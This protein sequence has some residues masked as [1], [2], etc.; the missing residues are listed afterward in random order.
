MKVS[1]SKKTRINAFI[2]ATIGRESQ[3]PEMSLRAAGN[4][5]ARCAA[6]LNAYRNARQSKSSSTNLKTNPGV[7]SMFNVHYI[8]DCSLYERLNNKK[9]GS[10]EIGDIASYQH[11]P[12]GEPGDTAPLGTTTASFQSVPPIFDAHGRVIFKIDPQTEE[13]VPMT[14]LPAPLPKAAGTLQKT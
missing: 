13:L 1:W 5:M 2:V 8:T 9:A 6:V 14:K 4:V 3:V 10:T 7:S 11:S 12:N